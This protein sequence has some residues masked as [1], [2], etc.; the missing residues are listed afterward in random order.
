MNDTILFNF[1][2]CSSFH[3][4]TSPGDILPSGDTAVASCI[5][6]PAPPTA[7][8]PKC[9]RCQSVAKPS[10]DEYWHMGETVILFLNVTPLIFN[11]DNR[12]D[13][14]GVLNMVIILCD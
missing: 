12:I 10:S 8:L 11:G 2:T 13:M 3:S 9:T 1:P 6:S 14:I 4:P 7:L 5:I